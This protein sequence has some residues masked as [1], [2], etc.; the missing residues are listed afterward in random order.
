MLWVHNHYTY[1]ILSVQGLTSDSDVCRCQ[2]LMSEVGCQI[3][4]SEVDPRAE[5]VKFDV[6][7]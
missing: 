5:S 1:F 3:L 4:T 6:L 7:V 2:I